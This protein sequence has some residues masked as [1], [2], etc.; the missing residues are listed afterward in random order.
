MTDAP[1]WLISLVDS[2]A[3]CMEAAAPSGPVGYR[4]LNDDGE[5]WEVLVYSTPVQLVG[6]AVDGEIVYPLF[7][8]DLQGLSSCF[9]EVVDFRWQA[10]DFGP[11]DLEG[12]HVSVEGVYRGRNVYLRVLSEPPEDEEPGMD[13]EVP[14]KPA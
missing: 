10:Q 3:D 11:H 4:W 13:L 5:F 6:G 14:T 12:P 1:D 8:L 9:D 7:S 2:V